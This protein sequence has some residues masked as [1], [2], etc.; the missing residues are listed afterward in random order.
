MA[1]HLSTITL[2]NKYVLPVINYR[3]ETQ[4]LTNGWY[5]YFQTVQR[6]KSNEKH[7]MKKQKK[8]NLEIFDILKRIKIV[9]GLKCEWFG[10]FSRIQDN[11]Q[12]KIIRHWYLREVKQPRRPSQ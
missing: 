12:S 4:S 5:K 7:N 8:N 3:V 2:Y 10:R 11:R 1:F 9:N 6:G